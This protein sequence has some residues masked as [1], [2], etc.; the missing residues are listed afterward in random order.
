MGKCAFCNNELSYVEKTK[1]IDND[2]LANLKNRGRTADGV[3]WAIRPDSFIIC[4]KC[5]KIF[6]MARSD[7]EE[8]QKMATDYLI[9][10]IGNNPAMDQDV[11]DL[12]SDLM[13]SPKEKERKKIEKEK[14]EAEKLK[15]A[16]EVMKTI[17][18]RQRSLRES[19]KS[20]IVTTIDLKEEYEIIGPVYY[21][22]SNKGIFASTLDVKKQ[23]YSKVL[24]ER[25]T[26]GMMSDQKPDYGFLVGEW[27]VGQNDFDAAFYIAVDELKLRAKRMGADAIV[28]MHQ[29]ID[30]DT[31]GFSYFYLQIYG[32]A[33]RF[34]N[35]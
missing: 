34:K 31:N 19:S 33:V 8:D 22:I 32:T 1:N 29:D 5:T 6:N 23:E 14:Q 4:Q 21:Q 27:T 11:M 20:V 30:I 15:R 2:V 18:E 3:K 12:V 35:K 24:S 26:S 9:D 25:Q 28:G 10:C 13:E 7:N 16:E 17:K